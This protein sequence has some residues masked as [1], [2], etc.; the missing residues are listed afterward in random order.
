MLGVGFRQYRENE[1]RQFRPHVS[2]ERS[3][4]ESQKGQLTYP[5]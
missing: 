1:R 5:G 2:F 4:K 3:G